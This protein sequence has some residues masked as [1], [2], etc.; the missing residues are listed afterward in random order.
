M[1]LALLMIHTCSTLMI[2]KSKEILDH[3]YKSGHETALK[4]LELQQPTVEKLKLHV[5]NHWIMAETGS[6]QFMIVCSATTSASG[7][8]N[9]SSTLL[10][11][12]IIMYTTQHMMDYGSE[13]KRVS[14]MILITQFTGVILGTVA[15]LSRCF[16]FLSFKVSI[17][18][19]WKHIKVFKVESYYTQKLSYWKQSSV[20]FKFSSRG[21]KIVIQ[22]LKVFILSCCIGF[23]KM[24]AV[25]CNMTVLVPMF[26]LL[27]ILY[28]VLVEISAQKQ[29]NK[30]LSQYVLLLQDDMELAERTLR[31]IS[32]SV[33]HLIQKAEKQQ[34]NSLMKLLEEY[35][36]F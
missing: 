28:N 33:N 14:F 36:G 13:Y 29:H 30:A 12:I 15:P 35:N 21:F 26:I 8:I 18:Q 9:V 7:V 16:A 1:L 5:S 20:P 4:D 6:P 3:K 11:G 17:K 10:H 2:L 27:G 31:S 32:K 25:A 24:V 34:P 23:Q 19:I 22:D